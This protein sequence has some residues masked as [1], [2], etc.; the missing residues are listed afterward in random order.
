MG[1]PA[2]VGTAY[3]G[4]DAQMHRWIYDEIDSVGEYFVT[5]SESP[6]LSNSSWTSAFPAGDVSTIRV[7]SRSQYTVDGRYVENGKASAFHQVCKR[8]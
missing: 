1:A 8:K 7:I 2:S 3:L 5:K 6:R 4:Y